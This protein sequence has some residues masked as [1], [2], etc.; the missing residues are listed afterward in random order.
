[1]GLDIDFTRNMSA[2]FNLNLLNFVILASF[3]WDCTLKTAKIELELLTE[4]DM[5]IDY[6]NAI[7]GGIITTIIIIVKLINKYIHNYDETKDSTYIQYGYI[8][9]IWMSFFHN[10]FSMVDLN[11]LK[12]FQCLHILQRLPISLEQLK[13]DFHLKIC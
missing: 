6:K 3:S 7:R 9:S 10:H 12:I 11:M 13:M 8:Q 5:I 1:M 2:Q 4:L